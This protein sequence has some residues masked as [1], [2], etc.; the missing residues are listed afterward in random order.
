LNWN[1]FVEKLREVLHPEYA[2]P[3]RPKLRAVAD[4]ERAD[5][6]AAASE[7]AAQKASTSQ[8]PIKPA[9]DKGTAIIDDSAVT[10]RETVVSPRGQHQECHPKGD[11]ITLTTQENTFI[12]AKSVALDEC[13]DPDELVYRS[14]YGAEEELDW[15]DAYIEAD[16]SYQSSSGSIPGTEDDDPFDDDPFDDDPFDDDPFGDGEEGQPA[17]KN[18]CQLD[19]EDD[20]DWLDDEDTSSTPNPERDI[21][22]TSSFLG[23]EVEE[24]KPV[25]PPEPECTFSETEMKAILQR[26]DEQYFALAE[27]WGAMVDA[28]IADLRTKHPSMSEKDAS[29]KAY[30]KF[31]TPSHD[32][33][34]VEARV[35]YIIYTQ[36]RS[37][38]DQDAMSRPRSEI[39]H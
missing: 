31:P 39:A 1:V 15:D 27:E 17:L 28:Y 37:R 8:S 14:F 30:K 2:N 23:T 12:E 5:R 16:K 29:H 26:A 4:A 6:K 18:E 35:W 3:R 38:G 11:A 13:I 25:A 10:E 9:H 22:T 7:C 32:T 20:D 33:C 19:V 21:D 24:S 36:G 34:V